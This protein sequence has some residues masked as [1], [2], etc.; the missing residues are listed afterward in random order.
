MNPSANAAPG[1]LTVSFEIS[2]EEA[3]SVTEVITLSTDAVESLTVTKS[4]ISP[5]NMEENSTHIMH[6]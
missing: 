3:L 2:G 6:L 1:D 4:T 5:T